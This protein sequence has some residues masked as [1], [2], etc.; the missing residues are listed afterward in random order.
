MFM[1]F[2]TVTWLSKYQLLH[3]TR[4]LICIFV[5][6]VSGCPLLKCSLQNERNSFQPKEL[7]LRDFDE[8]ILTFIYMK[9]MC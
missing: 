9:M 3:R 8:E 2:Y 7:V 1:L 6:G 5:Y 4:L